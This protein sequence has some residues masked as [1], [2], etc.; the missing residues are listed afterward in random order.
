MKRFHAIVAVALLTMSPAFAGVYGD[1]L[2]RCLV[3]KSTPEEKS[4]L[5]QWIFVAMSRHPSVSSFT[6]ITA[7][8]VERYNKIAGE[9]FTRLLTETC[10]EPS[11]KAIR[12][13]G[14][15]AFQSAFQVL[16]QVAAGDLFQ[17]PEVAAVMGGLDKY[18][19]A[20]KLETLSQ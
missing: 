3:E 1:D 5:V 7:D 12:Y 6:R 4:L 19:D 20:K 16:G 14:A 17:N 10:A 11:K 13:E 15:T 2:S 9:L 18:L 8:D